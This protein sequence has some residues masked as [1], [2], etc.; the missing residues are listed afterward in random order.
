MSFQF[1]F[2]EHKKPFAFAVKYIKLLPSVPFSW[3]VVCARTHWRIPTR[4]IKA[5]QTN[6]DGGGRGVDVGGGSGTG[7]GVGRV[8]PDSLSP[9]KS[10]LTHTQVL[11]SHT[12][13][14]TERNGGWAKG[15]REGGSGGVCSGGV[16][17]DVA[18]HCCCISVEKSLEKAK[19][20]AKQNSI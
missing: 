14:C 13:P 8:R 17:V 11:H 12:R 16:G 19:R 9:E 6:G 18:A 7:R 4:H 20:K 3:A 5:G 2:Y 1:V 10:A 15:R